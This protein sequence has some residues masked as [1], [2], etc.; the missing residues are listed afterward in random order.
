VI[1]NKLVGKSRARFVILHLTPVF[2]TD[3]L[4]TI[5]TRPFAVL[6]IVHPKGILHIV[7]SLILVL[8]QTLKNII[9]YV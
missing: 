7:V 6:D 5:Y 2:F 9:I 1:I 4:I 8:A 3:V